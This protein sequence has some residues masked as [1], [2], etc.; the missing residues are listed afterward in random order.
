MF[1]WQAFRWL[2]GGG[3]C[4]TVLFGGA[5]VWLGFRKPDTTANAGPQ[6]C[7]VVEAS[8]EAGETP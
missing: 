3:C 2:I 4:A 1:T 8:D 6:P 7:H 5:A